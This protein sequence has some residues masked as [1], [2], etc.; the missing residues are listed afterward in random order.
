MEAK[1]DTSLFMFSHGANLIYLLLYVDDIVLTA[2]STVLLHR[3]ITAL[4]QEFSMK[5]LGDLHHF[6]GMQVQR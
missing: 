1:P 2:S 5:D 3:T 6:R 4:R